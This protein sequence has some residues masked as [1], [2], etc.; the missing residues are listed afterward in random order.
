MGKGWDDRKIILS[1]FFTLLNPCNGMHSP[2]LA[3]KKAILTSCGIEDIVAEI[4]R[5]VNRDEME[6]FIGRENRDRGVVNLHTI[7][8]FGKL[9]RMKL[10]FEKFSNVRWKELAK[11]LYDE[12]AKLDDESPNK[13]DS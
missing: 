2:T 13:P 5:A 1:S 3:G 11:S 7:A 12:I 8:L 10:E 6:R 4:M 9:N